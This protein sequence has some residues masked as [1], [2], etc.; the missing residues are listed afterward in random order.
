MPSVR[1]TGAVFPAVCATGLPVY[2]LFGPGTTQFPVLQRR[3]LRFP[4]PEP[5]LG[6][7]S[8]ASTAQLSFSGRSA[9]II[10]WKV[11]NQMSRRHLISCTAISAPVA[12]QNGHSYDRNKH[13]CGQKTNPW[14]PQTAKAWF[15]CSKTSGQCW[16]DLP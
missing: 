15:K 4:A 2:L 10:G 3:F 1:R 14:P 16:G 13:Y 5:V 7:E 8:A 9:A 11:E 12:P 6:P